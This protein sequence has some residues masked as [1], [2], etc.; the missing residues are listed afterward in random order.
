MQLIE[1]ALSF[2][3]SSLRCAEAERCVVEVMKIMN[4]LDESKILLLARRLPQYV[5]AVVEYGFFVG[6]VLIKVLIRNFI[7]TSSTQIMF[8]ILLLEWYG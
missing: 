6:A 5:T 7:S 4:G 8:L 3:A 2:D 1:I